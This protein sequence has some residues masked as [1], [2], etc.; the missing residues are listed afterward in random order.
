MPCTWVLGMFSLLLRETTINNLE[1]LSINVAL[2]EW[3]H[4]LEGASQLFLVWTDHK[5]LEYLQMAK[6]FNSRKVRWALFSDK[7]HFTLLSSPLRILLPSYPTPMLWAL[8]L[9]I[10]YKN[11]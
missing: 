5:N 11:Y 7:F 3:R 8:S 4:W 2:E 10:L 6:L 1:L 9:G